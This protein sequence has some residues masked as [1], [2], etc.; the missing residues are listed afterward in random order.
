MKRW[1]N[2]WKT[3]LRLAICALLLAWA[4]DS[5]F[6]KEGRS[7]V[8]KEGLKWNSLS[9][10][11]QSRAAWQHGPPVLSRNLGRIPARYLFGSFGLVG[12]T[13]LFGAVRW[14]MVMRVQG[15][16]LPPGLFGFVF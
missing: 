14:H 6:R 11:E 7:A 9:W 3:V 12:L 2:I 16:H 10:I 5:I 1:S 15:I 8:E 4:F 13:V